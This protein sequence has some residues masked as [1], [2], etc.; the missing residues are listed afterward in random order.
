MP[1]DGRVRE[2][3]DCIGLRC[4]AGLCRT[5]HPAEGNPVSIVFCAECNHVVSCYASG[6]RHCG[7][8]ISKAKP[9]PEEPPARK[10]PFG[11][12]VVTVATIGAGVA[13]FGD[14]GKG[15][16]GTSFPSPRQLFIPE[17]GGLADERLLIP[18]C[19]HD[20]RTCS[21]NDDW[22]RNADLNGPR[23]ACLA[24][25]AGTGA[26]YR[27][28]ALDHSWNGQRFARHI[29]GTSIRR[30]YV[31]LV[32]DAGLIRDTSGVWFRTSLHCAFD[33]GSGRVLRVGSP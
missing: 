7:A 29:P 18:G 31:V 23:G 28:T 33:V 3:R 20:W 24:A 4:D 22:I 32:D 11:A 6:C 12:V 14:P 25:V 8:P 30:G 27:D 1:R 13:F 19:R 2:K 15:K 16:P 9:R 17:M 26:A 10:S 5:A 21:D